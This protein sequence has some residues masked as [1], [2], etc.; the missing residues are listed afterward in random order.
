MATNTGKDWVECLYEIKA[1]DLLFYGR[2]LGL[3]HS[4]AEDVIQETF[5]ALLQKSV[6]PENPEHYLVRSFRNRALPTHTVLIGELGLSGEARPVP[7]AHLR[8]REAAAM[9]FRTCILP[10]GNLPL[11]DP[12]DGIALRPIR[13]VS[14]L[15]TLVF[16]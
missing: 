14:E 6:P 11:V 13:T 1:A 9:G 16:E 5:V 7:Q 8:V 12:V 15:S 2:A 3:S 4:E 10:A